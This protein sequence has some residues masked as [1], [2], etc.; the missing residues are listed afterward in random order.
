M[1]SY[2]F[3]LPILLL[4]LTIINSSNINDN[5]NNYDDNGIDGLD[6]F[7]FVLLTDCSKTA[8][9]TGNYMQQSTHKNPQDAWSSHSSSS[10]DK[11]NN[12]DDDGT[13]RAQDEMMS[14]RKTSDKAEPMKVPKKKD[15]ELE[16]AA[17]W[18]T[19]A[20]AGMVSKIRAAFIME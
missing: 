16:W 15:K 1:S 8:Q 5:T 3:V 13:S 6:C 10:N 17:Q 7:M 18:S 2:L 9:G 11:T 19:K 4:K 20:K 12:Y 14:K